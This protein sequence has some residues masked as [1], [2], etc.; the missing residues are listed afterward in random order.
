MLRAKAP[1]SLVNT[2]LAQQEDLVSTAQRTHDDFPFFEGY[3]HERSLKS[4]AWSVELSRSHAVGESGDQTSSAQHAI[5]LKSWS[6][7]LR[8]K[9]RFR[10]LRQTSFFR[11]KA[12][13]S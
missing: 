7:Y 12:S 13:N 11:D 4:V 3:E 5:S 2:T 8:P 1:A 10:K 9:A 6:S